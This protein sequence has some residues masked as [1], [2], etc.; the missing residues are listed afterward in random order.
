MQNNLSEKIE[1]EEPK[2]VGELFLLITKWEDLQARL[3]DISKNLEEKYRSD[4]II[5]LDLL[6]E[7]LHTHQTQIMRQIT[8]YECETDEERLAKLKFW[9]RCKRL[10][11]ASIDRFSVVDKIGLS[12]PVK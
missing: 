12:I 8:A 1:N 4:A 2:G 5:E 7:H 3:D 6:E 9:Q 11:S 10:G